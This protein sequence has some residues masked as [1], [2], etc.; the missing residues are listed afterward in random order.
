MTDGVAPLEEYHQWIQL[1]RWY[2]PYRFNIVSHEIHCVQTNQQVDSKDPPNRWYTTNDD[3]DINNGFM[4][5]N[6]LLPSDNCIDS[7]INQNAAV[8]NLCS[9][10]SESVKRRV[11]CITSP[12]CFLSSLNID[13]EQNH[14][15][16][17]KAKIA[18][19]YSGGIDSA[20]LA[21]LADR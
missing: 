17:P 13:N 6:R 2:N 16:I 18:I 3:G 21:A 8:D 10:L 4:S 14:K 1:Y 9:V 7:E 19:L 5:F 11:Y 12:S 20:I 15:N